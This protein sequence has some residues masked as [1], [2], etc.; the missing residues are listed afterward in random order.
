M[1]SLDPALV[2]KE[3]YPLL[4]QTGE[5]ADG[6]T[7]L[8]DRQH[9]HDLF[10]ELAT[11]YQI[12]NAT[13]SAF[14]YLALP[15]EP[16]L[17]PPV[18]M[19]RRS[20]ETDP[21]S[22]ITHHWLDSTHIAFGVATV[23]VVQGGW[24]LE[25]SAFKGREP[26]ENRT[27]IEAPRFD[28]GSARLSWNPTPAWA[29]QVSGGRLHSPESLTPGVDVDRVTASAMYSRAIGV[30]DLAVLA[31]WGQ[32]HNRP[33]ARLDAY[34]LEA[35][36][37]FAERN[38]VFARVDRV[39]KDELFVEPDPRAGAPFTVARVSAGVVRDVWTAPHL[40]VGLGA[41]VAFALV[42]A[43]LSDAYG[44]APFSGLFF[45]RASLR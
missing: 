13:H 22:P 17:G 29:L 37:E 10:M 34:L 21:E 44:D 43:A 2:G 14:V 32:N 39:G 5:S 7:P 31:A 4:L 24:K 20:G 38:T 28:S 3:G 11:T 9:P 8:I 35:S 25:G 16:A 6:V 26:D 41:M 18:F 1:L 12:A 45:A 42:P 36:A 23:G 40:R 15:G 30:G 27:D 19:H 33:G